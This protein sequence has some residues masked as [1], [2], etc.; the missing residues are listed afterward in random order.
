MID[1]ERTALIIAVREA[2]FVQR[3]RQVHL[4][5]PGV[6]M[7]PHVTLFAPFVSMNKI[8]EGVG[9]RL[10]EIIAENEPFGFNLAR[11]AHFSETGVLYLEPTPDE[12][13]K[14]LR[15]TIMQILPLAPEDLRPFV[16]H[17]T[18]AVTAPA[19]LEDLEQ[20]FL[21]SYGKRLPIEAKATKISLY[22]RHDNTW[23]KIKTFPLLGRAPKR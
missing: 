5:R 7:P 17:L 8:G 18:L 6:T 14:E 1:F 15:K 23:H 19:D 13:F 4:D 12:R 9:S 22:G 20:L 11:T 2:E 21:K 3:F 10:A 16:P